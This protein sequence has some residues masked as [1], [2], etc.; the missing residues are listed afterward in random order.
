MTKDEGET[1]DE[2]L[3]GRLRLY[4]PARGPRVSLDALLLADF[5]G[6]HA[7]G[8]VLDL[9]SGTGVIALVLAGQGL[10]KEG[11]TD[12]V[13]VELQP[14]L[15]ELATRNAELNGLASRCRFVRGDATSR[16][17]P[18]E[19]SSFDLV[20]ANPPFHDQRSANRSPTETRALAR[21]DHACTIHEIA[22]AAHRFLRPRG[23]VAVVFP[24]ERLPELFLALQT[25]K[26]TPRSLR[27][28]HS[29]HGE[30]ANRVLL[31]AARE[32]RGSL[33]VLSPLVI[34]RDDRRSYTDEAAR[35]LGD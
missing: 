25:A 3:R 4:Q 30:P 12:C 22:G 29:I 9:C 32:Y 7:R 6:A 33:S 17:L 14:K 26:L 13:G 28:V 10:S 8:R 11:V 23:Q 19:A 2:L 15:A 21:Q 16:A 18:L 5:A 20:V 1:L 34:H 31:L 24:S 35:I 27:F